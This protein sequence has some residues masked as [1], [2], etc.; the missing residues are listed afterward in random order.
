M[1]SQMCQ[2]KKKFKKKKNLNSSGTCIR[3]FTTRVFISHLLLFPW[4]WWV[5]GIV[6]LGNCWLILVDSFCG[7]FFFHFL[8]LYFPCLPGTPASQGLV[9]STKSSVHFKLFY[10]DWKMVDISSSV[11]NN[12]YSYKKKFLLLWCDLCVLSL[13]FCFCY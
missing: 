10:C 4:H 6:A 2:N 9:D 13:P 5:F 3:K 1:F 7:I 11:V 8:M 12:N